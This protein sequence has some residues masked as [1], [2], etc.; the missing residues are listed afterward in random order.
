MTRSH[1]PSIAAAAGLAALLPSCQFA[2]FEDGRDAGDLGDSNPC[3]RVNLLDGLDESSPEEIRDLFDCVNLDGAFEPAAPSVGALVASELRDGGAGWARLA[4]L[5]NYTLS[6]ADLAALFDAVEVLAD[7]GDE[8][9]VDALHLGTEWVF[10][11]AHAEL[12]EPLAAGEVIPTDGPLLPLVGAVREGARWILDEGETARLAEVAAA[13][14]EDEAVLGAGEAAVSLL[15]SNEQ[16][17]LLDPLPRDLVDTLMRLQDYGQAEGWPRNLLVDV[18]RDL[19]VGTASG[20]PVLP[21]LL[22]PLDGVLRGELNQRIF[23]D[24]VARLYEA[25]L[26]QRLPADLHALTLVDA[27]GRALPAGDPAAAGSVSALE[28]LLLLLEATDREPCID[29]GDGPRTLARFALET[30]YDITADP[31]DVEALA[32]FQ[33]LIDWAA[34][35]LG[36]FGACGLPPEIDLYTPAITVLLESPAL[37]S[38]I[39]FLGAAIAPGEP[40]AD[41][42]PELLEVLDVVVRDGFAP[43][44]DA[45][46]RAVALDP[47]VAGLVEL[48]GRGATSRDGVEREWLEA[49]LRGVAAL[50]RPADGGEDYGTAPLSAF[51]RPAAG[52]VSSERAVAELET[53]LPRVQALLHSEGSVTG[54]LVSAVSRLPGRD[55]L[56]P[57]AALFGDVVV[58]VALLE[59]VL[60]LV[61]DDE[62]MS[63]VLRGNTDR[64]HLVGFA[65][66]LLGD[67]T[68]EQFVGVLRWFAELLRIVS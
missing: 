68:G 42:L 33:G 6:V 51:L 39:P 7:G 52:L 41:R 18:L 10:G 14:A 55:E 19:L 45:A 38:L 29:L 58:D 5:V 32:A 3:Y 8:L 46:V 43:D 57:L 61:E 59:H 28:A 27:E 67:G 30:L 23:V 25:G 31:G 63:E 24:Q 40:G 17:G 64:E 49:G 66:R 20:P 47:S 2:P 12:E 50:V 1:R 36:G 13:M 65:G 21:D 62:L 9:L 26:L 37:D 53:A 56:E 34:D 22:P 44:L 11:R 4:A 15:L 16:H 35:L 60:M 48:L 54:D